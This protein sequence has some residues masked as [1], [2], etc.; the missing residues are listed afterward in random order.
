MPEGQ[1]ERL[2]HL[3]ATGRSS[4][5]FDGSHFIGRFESRDGGIAWRKSRDP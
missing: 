5:N 3:P 4:L 2:I 1:L